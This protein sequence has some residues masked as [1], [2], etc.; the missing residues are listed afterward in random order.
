[1]NDL[2]FLQI[3]LASLVLVILLVLETVIPFVAGRSHRTKN[4]IV[5]ISIGVFNS[6]VAAI[7][8]GTALVFTIEWSATHGI[9]LLNLIEL[10]FAIS[11]V[12]GV[13][14]LDGW[15]YLW[16]RANHYFPFL[17]RFHRV[18][19]SDC[20]MDVTTSI[21]FHTG[22]IL[23]SA[24]LRL[25]VILV[26]GLSLWHVLLYDLFLVPFVFFHHSNVRFSSRWDRRLRLL[27]TSPSMHRIHHSPERIDADSN[28]GSIFSFW[29]RLANSFSL[30]RIVDSVRYGL[31]DIGKKESLRVR[32]LLM[33]P[34]K[35]GESTFRNL[36]KKLH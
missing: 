3:A 9:G 7:T 29:D 14:F 6:I 16:H 25:G 11:A 24:V 1:M 8:F 23:I 28:Y 4:A 35:N 22:E 30:K 18:H 12:V 13:V 20:E 15:M 33:L 2:L 34:L 5:N 10:P 31:A 17:W 21:R 26:L 32:T 27:F 19:H 36:E